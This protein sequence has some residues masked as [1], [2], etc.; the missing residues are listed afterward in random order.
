MTTD[1]EKQL[2]LMIP[3]MRQPDLHT[4][5]SYTLR[6]ARG[7]T[8]AKIALGF[9]LGVLVTYSF[10]QPNDSARETGPQET[11]MLVF[12]D[13]SLDQLRRPADLF[14]SVVRVPVPV[15][16]LEI[17]IDQTQWQYG[18]LRNSLMRM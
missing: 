8:V 14:Q 17:D 15:P 16:K 9:L 7:Y 6:P 4:R 5:T 10:M 12:D 13:S 1:F 18:T 3:M 2:E 11:F